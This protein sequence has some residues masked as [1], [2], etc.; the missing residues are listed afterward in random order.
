MLC[1]KYWSLLTLSCLISFK[2]TT[3]YGLIDPITGTFAVGAF[4]A[5]YFVQKSNY[6]IPFFSSSCPKTFDVRK[7]KLDMD[8]NFFGQHI[9]S[10]IILS[11]LKGNFRRSNHN[12][13]PLVMSFHGWTGCGKNFISDLIANRMFGSEK[14]KKLRYHIIHGPRDYIEQ[15]NL[16]EYKNEMRKNIISAIKSCDTNLFVFDELHYMPNGM[17]DILIPILENHDASVDSRN[18]IFI[19]LTN[20]GSDAI[21]EKYLDLWDKGYSREQMKVQDFDSILQKSAF[22]EIGGL[23]RSQ[24]IDSHIIDHFIPFLPMEKIHMTQ[25]IEA[26]LRHLNEHLDSDKINEILEVLSFGPEPQKLFSIGGCKRIKAL[27]TAAT[28]SNSI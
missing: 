16:Y 5:G 8:Q 9:A 25:C 4:I 11:A 26:E 20:A 24:V 28:S 21:V 1:I 22:N 10:E 13:K 7:L 15:T 2:S 27:V 17:L 18:S 23:K 12:K 3:V 19:L 6:Q 14:V